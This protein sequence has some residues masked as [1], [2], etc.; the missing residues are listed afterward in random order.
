MKTISF[1]ASLLALAMAAGAAH[2]KV[3]TEQAAKLGNEL[4]LVGAQQ[5]ANATG[6]IP[7]YTGGLAQD[8]NSDPYTNIYAN[9]K[10]LFI[11]SKSNLAQYQD[12]LTQGQLAM[13]EKYPDTYT[14]PI[15]QTHRTASYPQNILDKAQK[16]ATTTQLLEGGNGL[17]NFDETVPFAIPKNGLEVIW[18]HVTRFRGG[19]VQLNQ[20]TV[21]VQRNGSFTPIK[22][23]AQFTPPQ[24]LKDGFD[25]EKDN[26]ILFYYTSAIKSPAR[27]TGNVLL[28]HETIDQVN[29]PRKAWQYNAGQRRVRRAPQVAYDAPNTEGLRTTDQVDMYNGAPNRYN[30][31]LIGKKEVYIPYNSYKIINKDAKY[32]DII[33]AGHINQEYTRYELHRVWHIEA[34]L[35]EDARHIYGKRALYLDEDSWQIA[36]ADHYD[37]RGE[38]WRVSE[39]HTMQFVNANTPWYSSI[40]NYDLVSGRYMVELNSE[41]RDAFKF[42]AQVKRKDFTTGAIRRSGK[43]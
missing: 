30:W 1:T 27:L 43:R 4:T 21:P 11:I 35:K 16:N 29:E 19:S 32:A 25:A 13:F 3:S 5:S 20:A 28:V 40:T 8:S 2:A 38:L 42:N 15:Y 6:S 33:G 7:S 39:G 14:M 10:P 17:N 31:K 34:T 26:N 18:N 9:E 37:N 23:R 12:N 22:I 24:Y 36:V 41:E